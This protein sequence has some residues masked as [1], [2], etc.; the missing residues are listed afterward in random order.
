MVWDGG[1]N[2]GTLAGEAEEQRTK[3]LI[4]RLKKLLETLQ[5]IETSQRAQMAVWLP[6]SVPALEQAE[7]SQG[8]SIHF[9]KT[10]RKI[11]F[12]HN[13]FDLVHSKESGRSQTRI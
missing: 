1:F 4:D 6:R 9:T 11:T 3:S 7:E 2:F 13:K 8:V 12:Y 10:A 5:T